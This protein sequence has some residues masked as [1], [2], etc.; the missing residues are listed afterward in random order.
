MKL[1]LTNDDGVLREGLTTLRTRLIR[2]GASVTV[3]APDGNR[4]GIGRGITLA[5]PVSIRKLG[6]TPSDPIYACSGTPV[7]CVR[8]GLLSS[9][10]SAPDLVVSGINHGLNVGDDSTYSG[11]VGA[12]LEASLLGF[13][14]VAFSQQAEEGSFKFN[15]SGLPVSFPFA[16]TAARIALFLAGAK[17]PSPA[18]LNINF[19][20]VGSEAEVVLTRP[21]RR[22]Y[23][24]D[25]LEPA[26]GRAGHLDFFPYGLPSDSSFPHED[27]E[28]TDF[29]AL[30]HGRISV[31]VFTPRA[32]FAGDHELEPLLEG[33]RRAVQ[34]AGFPDGQRGER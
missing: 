19:P 7:D 21:G 16:E 27:E 13:P 24:D 23:A 29:F 17:P 2:L 30:G 15:D 18:V 25:S 28:G 14:A 34:R 5:D 9:L 20:A 33:L 32:H 11:T 8:I 4:S 3:I 12:A 10:A 31:S 26:Q 1:L 22:F 6:G